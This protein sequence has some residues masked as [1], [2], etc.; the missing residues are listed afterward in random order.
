VPSVKHHRGFILAIDGPAGSGKST[1]ARLCAERLGFRHLDTGAMYRAVAL[2]VLRSA[3]GTIVRPDQC[4]MQNAKCKVQNGGGAEG[5]ADEGR[6]ER[7]EART[8]ID[9]GE[10]ERLLRETRVSVGWDERGMRT[11]LDGKDVS[12]EIRTP[13]VSAFVSEV[14]AIPAV[15]K[16]MVAEQRRVAAGHSIVCEGRDTGSVV[17]PDADLKIFLDCDTGERARRRQLELG[18][19]GSRASRKAV[20]DN[21]VKRDRIDSGREVSPLRRMPDAI[22]IDTTH[23]TIEE[24]VTVVCDM[25]RRRMEVQGSRSRGF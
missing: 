18:G 7:L 24:Q 12:E 20:R 2:K 1:T 16:K 3:D 10:M 17:F 8:Q 23:L 14:S 9:R 6:S 19:Q 11:L 15:R 5:A 13:A 25:A 21:L 4:K 22:L